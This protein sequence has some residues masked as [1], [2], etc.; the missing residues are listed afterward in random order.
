MEGWLN[1]II[2]KKV[3]LAIR[4]SFKFYLRVVLFIVSEVE[5]ERGRDFIKDEVCK[6]SGFSKN[7]DE[8][9]DEEDD[10]QKGCAKGDDTVVV[11][12]G[13]P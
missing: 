8:P 12:R 13:Q 9:D 4:I 1:K 2:W 11:I 10:L 3:P 7:K 5:S 6:A